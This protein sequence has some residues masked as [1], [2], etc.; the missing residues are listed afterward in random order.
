M[1]VLVFDESVFEFV[2]Y[3]RRP[4]RYFFLSPPGYWVA[5]PE[6]SAW[7]D[8]P[9]SWFF[10]AWLVPPGYP[11][12]CGQFVFVHVPAD[13]FHCPGYCF[14]FV[15]FLDSDSAG[16]V[17]TYLCRQGHRHLLLNRDNSFADALESIAEFKDLCVLCCP[18]LP[19]LAVPLQKK[20]APLDVHRASRTIFCAT[21]TAV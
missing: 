19:V 4:A 14:A 10:H 6:C 9:G 13:F 18:T 5:Q 7:V 3:V 16:Q 17:Q 21:R 12:I 15:N 2:V 11:G 1:V 8:P 20:L